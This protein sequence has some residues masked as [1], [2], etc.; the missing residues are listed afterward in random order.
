MDESFAPRDLIE[1]E[2]LRDLCTRRDLPS[3]HR[4]AVHVGAIGCVTLWLASAARTPWSASGGVVVL[5]ALLAAQF[6]PFHECTH[7][8][9]FASRRANEIGAWL[10]GSLWLFAPAIYRVFH[11]EHHRHTQDPARDPEL[12]G[13]LDVHGVWPRSLAGWLKLVPVHLLA[14]KLDVM[15]RCAWLPVTRWRGFASWASAEDQAACTRDARIALGL[16]TGVL[17]MALIGVAGARPFIIAAVL[18][19]S[20]I[21]LWLPCE[22]RGLPDD[23]NIFART[24]TTATNAWVRFWIWNMNYHAEHHAWPAIPWHRLPAAHALARPHLEHH[25]RGYLAMHANVLTGRNRPT[26]DAPIER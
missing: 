17:V 14:M 26:C 20:F 16:W 21:G 24:R 15:W 25:V 8:T 23:G 7:R 9:A 2:T 10:C 22:H 12:G 3:V 1:R 18:S 11:F 19:H 6:A 5:A 13:Q 4:L